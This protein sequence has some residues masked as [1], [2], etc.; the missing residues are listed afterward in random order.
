M[1][2]D[3]PSERYTG[4]AIALHWLLALALGGMIAIGNNMHDAEGRP[5]SWLFQLHKS[6][7]I[8]ILVLVIARLAWRYLNPPPQLPDGMTPLEEKASHYVH[9][10]LYAL[11]VL[12]PLT[13]WIMVSVSP[14]AIATVLFGAVGWPHLPV[15]PE[16]A[17]ETR[18]Q[19]Y[20]N[21]EFIHEIL[22]KLLF[23]L[24]VL[25]VAGSIKHELSDDEGVLKRMIPGL[26]GKTTPPRAP[27]RGALT[28]FGSAAAFFGIIAGAPVVAQTLSTGAQDVP[29]ASNVAAN[30][31]ID[32]D[33]SSIS[34]AGDYNG[35][36]YQG[37]FSDWSAD[38]A[39]DPDALDASAVA[40]TVQT[41]TAATG[42]SL[43]DNTLKGGEWFNVSA[44]PTASVDLSD[45]TETDSGYTATAALTI[46]ELTIEIPFD[47]TLE[48]DD[49]GNAAMIGQTTLSRAA[50]DLGQQSD[51]SGD[52]V[53]DAVEINVAVKASRS[54]G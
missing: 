42:T 18:E 5:I 22:S 48:I 13:G 28:A 53:A 16:L 6:I 29:A 7:G 14:F 45:F 32:Y 2:G 33:A 35:N 1:T 3:T 50:L 9:L 12:L 39:F 43:Y 4:V 17:L 46:K 23:L 26:F 11:M 8:T 49:S 27:S 15:L 44:F 19:I 34:F 21:V 54:E 10:G 52:W 51:A 31:T 25:H 24:F 41:D 20:P 36:P 47:F 30:W 37:V 38:I 40:V